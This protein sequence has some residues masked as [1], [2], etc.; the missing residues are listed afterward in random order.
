MSGNVHPNSAPVFPCSVCAGNVSWQGRSLQCFICSKWVHLKRSLLSFAKLRTLRSTHSWS[1]LTCCVPAPS[2]DNTVTSSS[3]SSSLYTSTVQSV[4]FA[5]SASAALSPTL[6]FK[7]LIPL[8]LP[9]YLLPLH[10]HHRL[11]SWLYL[12]TSCFL[13]FSQN[14]SIECWGIS[15]PGTVNFYTF[16]RLIPLTLFVS[17]NLTLIHVLLSG[18]LDYLFWDLIAPTPGLAFSLLMPR[19]LAVASSFSSGRAY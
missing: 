1:N 17:R 2:K 5:L 11:I 15:E 10:S 16:F 4:Q 7:H 14:S 6:A 8:P 13:L 12:Y 19:T 9:S 18:F 3:D